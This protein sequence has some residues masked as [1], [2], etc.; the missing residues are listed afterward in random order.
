MHRR[1]NTLYSSL[2]IVEVER[3][4]RHK[5]SDVSEGRCHQIELDDIGRQCWEDVKK[6]APSQR[7]KQQ[8]ECVSFGEKKEMEM[9]PAVQVFTKKR[10]PTLEKKESGLVIRDRT[11]RN[12]TP[13]CIT[14][15]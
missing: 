9:E 4:C 5:S 14:G 12:F 15:I 6:Y 1:C 13:S 3:R 7:R 10:A 2:L 8:N 11:L